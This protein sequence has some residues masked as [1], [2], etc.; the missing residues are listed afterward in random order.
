MK[1]DLRPNRLSNP[2]RIALVGMVATAVSTTA[3][4]ESVTAARIDLSAGAGYSTNPFLSELGNSDSAFLE[5]A[6]RPNLSLIDDRG[7][8]ELGAYYSRSEYLRNGIKPSESYGGT[9]RSNRKLSEKVDV[10]ALLGYD[11]SIVGS[12]DAEGN[13]DPSLPQFPDIGL[14]GR[15]QRREMFNASVGA[16]LRPNARES[17]TVDFDGSK[18]RYPGETF[19][20]ANYKSYGGRLGYSRAIS[21]TTSI[22]ATVGYTQVDYDSAGQDSR[23]ISPQLTYSTRFAGGWSVSAALGVSFT[24]RQLIG[25]NDNSAALSGSLQGCRETERSNLCVG[26]SRATSATGI[27]GARTQTDLYATYSYRLSPR[28]TISSRISY[29]INGNDGLLLPGNREYLSANADFSH[30]LSERLRLTA[31][32]GYRDAYGRS[33]SPDADI[34]GSV[35]MAYTLGDRR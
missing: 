20:N 10:R 18:V 14:I 13:F 29:S 35:G 5:A 25:R 22:G 24:Q 17:W 16:T 19:F 31:S 27:G 32:A 26:G 4:A 33:I 34:R 12:A 23:I 7:R 15:Q 28:S 6:I 8:S 21:E 3:H 30:Q 11:S 1:P 2:A 9:A